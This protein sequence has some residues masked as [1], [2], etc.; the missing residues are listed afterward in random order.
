[1]FNIDLF[2]GT[3]IQEIFGSHYELP[4]LGPLGGYGLANVRDFESPLAHFDIDQSP[5]QITYKYA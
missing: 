1:M 2:P 5:W 3:D 4:E